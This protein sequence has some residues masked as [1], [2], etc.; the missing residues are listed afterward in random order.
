MTTP[1]RCF[2]CDA[3]LVD[4]GLYCDEC[5]RRAYARPDNETLYLLITV[6]AGQVAAAMLLAW[7]WSVGWL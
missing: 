7:L 6:A 3:P 5:Y 2:V 1:S 4:G